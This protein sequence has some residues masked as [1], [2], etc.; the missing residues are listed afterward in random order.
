VI[1]ATAACSWSMPEFAA[2]AADRSAVFRP[3]GRLSMAAAQRTRRRSGSRSAGEGA[4]A[5]TPPPGLPV[6]LARP[7]RQRD[8]RRGRDR[9]HRPLCHSAHGRPHEGGH[10]PRRVPRAA[11]RLPP[12]RRRLGGPAPARAGDDRGGRGAGMP[13]H[14]A[15]RPHLHGRRRDLADR[16]D[17]GV[18]RHRAGVLPARLHR[19][20]PAHRPG[21]P[22]SSRPRRSRAS[23]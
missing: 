5:R 23:R 22:R 3:I 7:E 10:R 11:D 13:P 14:A 6:P 17:R 8:R 1:E 15:R 19:H 2:R 16:R 9:G 20:R 21:R 4:A 18:L 12:D